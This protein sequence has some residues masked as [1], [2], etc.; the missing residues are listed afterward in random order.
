MFVFGTLSGV[1]GGWVLITATQAE[2]SEVLLISLSHQLRII[3]PPVRMH[4]VDA[5]ESGCAFGMLAF[6]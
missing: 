4:I 3:S 5:T 2:R 6:V 1:W